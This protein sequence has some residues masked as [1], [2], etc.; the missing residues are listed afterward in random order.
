M[1]TRPISTPPTSCGTTG[2]TSPSATPAPEAKVPPAGARPVARASLADGIDAEVALIKGPASKNVDLEMFAASARV[3]KDQVT[4]QAGVSRIDLHTADKRQSISSEKLTA[5]VNV[6]YTN[7]DGSVGGN[8]S[9][10]AT[11]I[12]VEGT[13]TVPGGGSSL[14]GGLSVGVGAELGVGTR[15]FDKDGHAE[16]CARVSLLVATVGACLENPF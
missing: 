11:L 10:G 5:K 12:G 2:S 3:N 15:D 7:P 14:T 9:I 4:L 6:S 8:A 13:L 1:S 16:L